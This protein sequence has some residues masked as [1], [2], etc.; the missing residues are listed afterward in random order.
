MSGMGPETV[1]RGSR[2][3]GGGLSLSVGLTPNLRT[4]PVLDGM[5]H[6]DGIDMTCLELHPS[7]LFW[8]QLKFA[9]FDIAEMSMSSML[10]AIAGGDDRFIGIPVFSTHY[11]FQ[12]WILVRK[13]SGIKNPK[14]LPGAASGYRNTSRRRHFGRAACWNMNSVSP[15]RTWNSGWNGHRIS[16]MAVPPDSSRPK[17]SPSTVYPQKPIWAKCCWRAN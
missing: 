15:R 2:A 3:G 5:F 12:N 7:E 9:E 11:F 17:V 10:M 1:K 4:R 16:V 13:D 14:T 6:A 8:R